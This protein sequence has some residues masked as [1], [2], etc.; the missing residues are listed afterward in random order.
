MNKFPIVLRRNV[1]SLEKR[2]WVSIA[3]SYLVSLYLD[4]V[5]IGETLK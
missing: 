5:I 3:I 4:F 1:I 2:K